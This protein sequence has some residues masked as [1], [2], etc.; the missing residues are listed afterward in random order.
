MKPLKAD[1]GAAEYTG[2]V[3]EEIMFDGSAST[4]DID[5]YSWVFS[6]GTEEHLSSSTNKHA[7]SRASDYHWVYLVIY[8]ADGN[9]DKCDADVII[10][11]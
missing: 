5:Y 10:T 8:G 2:T 9:S 7:F 4:G 11:S 3:G 1:C 6:D